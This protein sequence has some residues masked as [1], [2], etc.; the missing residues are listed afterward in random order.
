[1]SPYTIKVGRDELRFLREQDAI[2]AVLVETREQARYEKP[3]PVEFYHY[4][5]L[6]AKW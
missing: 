5:K 1:M 3:R 4:G 6:V 2:N